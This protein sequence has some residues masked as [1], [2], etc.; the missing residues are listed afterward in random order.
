MSDIN[1]NKSLFPAVPIPFDNQ[2]N[3]EEK[4]MENYAM[5]M[6]REPISG[7]ALWVHTGRGLLINEKQR[8][9]VYLTWRKHLKNE[10]KIICGVGAHFNQG[11]NEEK[12]Y[13]QVFSIGQQARVLGADAILVYPP[14]YYRDNEDM[15]KKVIEYHKKIAALGIPMVLF[16][17]Y[18][19]AGGISYSIRVLK[20]LFKIDLVEAIKMA[21]L[22][23]VCT[24][25]DV[26]TLINEDYPD[27]NLIT[28]EDRFFGY[29]LTRGAIGALVGLGAASPALQK[30]MIDKYLEGDYLSFVELMYKVDRFAEAIFISPMEGYIERLLYLLSLQGI[31]PE[32]VV[33]DPYGP[34]ISTEEKKNIKKMAIELD[35][36]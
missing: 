11:I 3:I 14:T 31:L 27:I 6:A 21:T 29:S 8:E 24:Y 2:G 10:Q 17:L 20:E 22:D 13:Q 30:S 28:G 5:Q 7:V 33:N 25:Q 34:G 12:Y 35:L 16:Y 4:A 36:L 23:S 15:E 9:Q 18:R 1:W 19:E 26:A 32:N